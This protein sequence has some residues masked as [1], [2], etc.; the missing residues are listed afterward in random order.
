MF[1]S[2]RINSFC[3]H[4]KRSFG[5]SK[6]SGK[7]M[8]AQFSRRGQGRKLTEFRWIYC[9]AQVPELVKRKN[10]RYVYVADELLLNNKI[11][12]IAAVGRW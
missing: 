7:V 3:S 10:Y 11:S 12:F 2:G 5:S 6:V 8:H 1:P 9:C 4:C